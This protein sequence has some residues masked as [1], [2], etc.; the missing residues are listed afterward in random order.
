MIVKKKK[1]SNHMK[2]K[3]ANE[4]PV[5]L[6]RATQL[7]ENHNYCSVKQLMLMSLELHCTSHLCIPPAKLHN[8]N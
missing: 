5:L 6:S 2:D 4:N 7:A 1:N 3:D 8:I